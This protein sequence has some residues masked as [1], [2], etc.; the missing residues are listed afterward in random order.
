MYDSKQRIL[1]KKIKELSSKF[2][3]KKQ[4]VLDESKKQQEIMENHSNT[5]EKQ[6]IDLRNKEKFMD[7]QIE[8]LKSQVDK[9]RELLKKSLI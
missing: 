9:E 5:L 7:A 8:L 2:N 6:L 4:K 3:V 1:D